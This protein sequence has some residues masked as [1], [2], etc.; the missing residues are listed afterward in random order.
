MTYRITK[1]SGPPYG[2]VIYQA[3]SLHDLALIVA[4]LEHIHH[5]DFDVG[6]AD[7]TLEKVEPVSARDTE[8]FLAWKKGSLC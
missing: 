3:D 1:H 7:V 5:I 2:P 4:E 8:A 6:S